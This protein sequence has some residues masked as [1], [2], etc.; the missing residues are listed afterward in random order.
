MEIQDLVTESKNGNTEAFGTIVAQ[1][2]QPLFRLAFRLLCNTDDAKDAVQDAFVKAWVSIKR[3]DPQYRFSTWLYRIAVRVCYDRLRSRKRR[4]TGHL[5]TEYADTTPNAEAELTGRELRHII[6]TLT[7]D[8]SPKQRLV[9]TLAD[10]E[11]LSTEEIRDATGLTPSSIKS[12]LYLA[13][14]HIRKNLKL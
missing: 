4:A 5:A 10:L 14:Q 11:E 2:R 3:Y 8:L 9:F 13:R 1:F 7:Q 12:N 6:T